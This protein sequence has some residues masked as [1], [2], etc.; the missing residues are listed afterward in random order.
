VNHW[1]ALIVGF[2]LGT[3]FGPKVFSLVGLGKS[4]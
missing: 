3:F 4:S 2:L 1:V